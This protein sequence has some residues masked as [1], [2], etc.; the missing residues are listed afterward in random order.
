MKCHRRTCF[1]S[2]RLNIFSDPPIV[3]TFKETIQLQITLNVVITTRIRRMTGGYI[4]SLCVCSHLG[5]GYPI[6]LMVGGIPSS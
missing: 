5:G 2:L 6:Q 3:A 4:F 1:H